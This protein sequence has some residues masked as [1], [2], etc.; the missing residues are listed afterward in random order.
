MKSAGDIDPSGP[1]RR[2]TSLDDGSRQRILCQPPGAMFSWTW[3]MVPEVQCG[4]LAPPCMDHR[5]TSELGLAGNPTV[6]PTRVHGV[7]HCSSGNGLRQMIYGQGFLATG[8][9]ALTQRMGAPA[10][11]HSVPNPP[12]VVSYLVCLFVF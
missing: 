11:G 8:R 5:M 3:Q 7:K 6:E 4:M 9:R 2:Y 10:T 1:G 12:R